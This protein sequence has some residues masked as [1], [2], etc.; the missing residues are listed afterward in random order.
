VREKWICRRLLE[1]SQEIS[2]I[3]YEDAN[4]I[5]EMISRC[6]EIVLKALMPENAD[7]V[8]HCREATIEAKARIEAVHLKAQARR[9]A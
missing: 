5:E 4:G 1:A 3:A 8:K 7:A 9:K 6:E 2:A